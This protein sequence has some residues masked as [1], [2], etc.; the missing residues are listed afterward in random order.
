LI[1]GIEGFFRLAN[2]NEAGNCLSAF[3]KL[4]VVDPKTVPHLNVL[5]SRINE[6]KSNLAD[7]NKSALEALEAARNEPS[8]KLLED[9]FWKLWFVDSKHP[10]DNPYAKTI[11]EL[12]KK[13][14][15]VKGLNQEKEK[16]LLKSLELN[17]PA[18]HEQL[19]SKA[20]VGYE[21]LRSNAGIN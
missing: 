12:N 5:W 13:Q 15:A 20:R 2:A 10:G 18:L 8:G 7:A 17:F 4:M 21:E 9:A 3:E 6:G 16:T 11:E 1:Q 14:F 19:K